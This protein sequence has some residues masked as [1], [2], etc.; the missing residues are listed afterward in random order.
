MSRQLAQV[1]PAG[2]TAV[3]LFSPT[4]ATPYEVKVVVIA[5]VS[6]ASLDVSLFHDADGTTYTEDTAL[7]FEQSLAAGGTILF[8]GAI[9]HYLDAGNLGCKVSV[10]NG[11]TFTAYGTVTG[12]RL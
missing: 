1:R 6:G 8:E 7:M 12:E 4:G 11:A 10:A 9:A 3:S 2:T 5:N